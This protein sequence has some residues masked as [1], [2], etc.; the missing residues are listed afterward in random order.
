MLEN[1]YNRDAFVLIPF[2]DRY[3]KIFDNY[4]KPPLSEY[5]NLTLADSRSDP[6]NIV[7]DIITGIRYADIIVAE[8]TELNP[9][10]M[11]EIA[12]AHCLSKPTVMLSMNIDN[13][14]FD[15]EHYRT[16]KYSEKYEDVI[17]LQTDLEKIA[18]EFYDSSL[19]FGNPVLDWLPNED[20]EKL[21]DWFG[22][23]AVEEPHFERGVLDYQVE[24]ENALRESTKL[25][26]DLSTKTR[27]VTRKLS[28][29]TRRFQQVKSSNK[30]GKARKLQK[31]AKELA[32]ELNEYSEEIKDMPEKFEQYWA[33]IDKCSSE[34]YSADQFSGDNEGADEEAIV[35]VIVSARESLKGLRD[36]TGKS[37]NA[38]ETLQD[39]VSGDIRVVAKRVEDALANLEQ[40]FDH[41]VMTLDRVKQLLERR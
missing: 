27:S 11:Y 31:V 16:I 37:R 1:K 14:P 19:S 10:V 25:T 35:D 3:R 29:Y 32:G 4:I 39:G 24:L 2:D 40:T 8:V 36:N 15:F 6:K 41:G 7:S 34:L 12:V 18:V 13:L 33:T 17:A 21:R 26:R 22:I 28:Q 38:V 20:S 9:N 30:A 23:D 5:F